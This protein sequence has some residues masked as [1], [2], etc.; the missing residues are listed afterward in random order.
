MNLKKLP[1]IAIVSIVPGYLLHYYLFCELL[2]RFVST[3]NPLYFPA[4]WFSLFFCIACFSALGY[5]V[6]YHKIPRYLYFSLI[7]LYAVLLFIT[8]FGRS[9]LHAEYIWN[10]ADSF[11]ALGEPEMKL[12]SLFNFLCF[13]PMDYF[14]RKI[15]FPLMICSAIFLSFALELLQALTARGFFDTFDIILYVAGITAGYGV[16]KLLKLELLVESKMKS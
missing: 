11:A 14:F 7:A 3:G 8:L 5:I 9:A 10:P 2:T 15:K 13:V 6:L 12:Q 16:T 1:T 4:M